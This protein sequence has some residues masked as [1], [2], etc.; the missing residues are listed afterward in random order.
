MAGVF[1]QL[2]AKGGGV[3]VVISGGGGGIGRSSWP[4][5]RVWVWPSYH[6]VYAYGHR[7]PRGQVSPSPRGGAHPPLPAQTIGEEAKRGVAQQVREVGL[8]WNTGAAVRMYG[9][10]TPNHQNN[11]LHK[12]QSCGPCP[13]GLSS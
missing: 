4:C 8:R 3:C 12:T 2:S 5:R 10:A 1:L 6:Q 7:Q 9:P 11:E 13:T